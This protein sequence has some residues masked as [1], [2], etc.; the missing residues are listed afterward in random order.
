[1]RLLPWGPSW[2]P[3]EVYLWL[4]KGSKETGTAEWEDGIEQSAAKELISLTPPEIAAG[5]QWRTEHNETSFKPY[6]VQA[7]FL[8]FSTCLFCSS[9]E[10]TAAEGRSE[11][12]PPR[13]ENWEPALLCSFMPLGQWLTKPRSYCREAKWSSLWTWKLARPE[14]WDYRKEDEIRA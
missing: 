12:P 7:L 9:S 11:T 13:K 10:V 1:M 4:L 8:I 14:R 2:S 6:F 5:S 3:W